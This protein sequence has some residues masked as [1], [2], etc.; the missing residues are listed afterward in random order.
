MIIRGKKYEKQARGYVQRCIEDA[1]LD[2]GRTSQLK[3][4]ITGRKYK[5]SYKMSIENLINRMKE[6]GLNIE[7]V[8]GDKRGFW[9]GYYVRK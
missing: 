8:P 6:H 3:V 9:N 2:F 4:Y 7:F 1:L 5:D